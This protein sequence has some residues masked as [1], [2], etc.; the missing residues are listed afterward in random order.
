VGETV[1]IAMWV[2]A[3]LLVGVGVG[4]LF[5]LVLESSDDAFVALGFVVLAW[6]LWLVLMACVG[7]GFVVIRLSGLARKA[8]SKTHDRPD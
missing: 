1:S 5:D 6:P 3:Y 8:F 2:I 7:F 4:V